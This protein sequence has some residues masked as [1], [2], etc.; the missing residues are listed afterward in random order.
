MNLPLWGQGGGQVLAGQYEEE[1]DEQDVQD[2]DSNVEYHM[3]STRDQHDVIESD[4]TCEV[5][6]LAIGEAASSFIQT[7]VELSPAVAEIVDQKS[8]GKSV[9]RK[10]K[11]YFHKSRDIIIGQ[12]KSFVDSRDCKSWT[13]ALFTKLKARTVLILSNSTKTQLTSYTTVDL[14]D[15]DVLRSLQ[16]SSYTNDINVPLL[17]E[18]VLLKDLT[19]AVFSY[20]EEKEIPAT[21]YINFMESHFID[22]FTLKTYKALFNNP[23]LKDKVSMVDLTV[24]KKRL[25]NFEGIAVADNNLYI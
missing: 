21:V 22:V 7:F 20:C 23:N 5:F 10:K 1:E 2:D 4:L 6:V 15:S 24:L 25:K 17:E 8:D 14:G 9:A 12:C 3:V 11:C 19:A 18:G 13:Q 16:T